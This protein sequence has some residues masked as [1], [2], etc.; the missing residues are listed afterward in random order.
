MDENRFPLVPTA[1]TFESA[2]W[3]FRPGDLD[4]VRSAERAQAAVENLLG[5]SHNQDGG[6]QLRLVQGFSSYFFRSFHSAS[7]IVLH[8]GIA[9]VRS[10]N[11]HMGQGLS[12]ILRKRP[13]S[14]R[15]SVF[16]FRGCLWP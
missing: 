3:F 1:A 5:I 4:L 2:H 13:V 7:V 10:M 15:K 11:K 9:V 12:V 8:P 14:S 6:F 16:K